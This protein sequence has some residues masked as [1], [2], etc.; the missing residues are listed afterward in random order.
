MFFV[1]FITELSFSYCF[2][3]LTSNT[4]HK[5]KYSVAELTVVKTNLNYLL[6]R[7]LDFCYNQKNH[8]C[9]FYLHTFQ[10][11][12]LTFYRQV[13]NNLYPLYNCV[14][15]NMRPSDY[16]PSC[17]TSHKLSLSLRNV[18]N[19]HHICLVSLYLKQG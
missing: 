8:R 16:H 3:L 1:K 5:L 17:L 12:V 11:C 2:I 6:W 10:A 18:Q 4:R 19:I 15:H 7:V 9:I 13:L 14:S